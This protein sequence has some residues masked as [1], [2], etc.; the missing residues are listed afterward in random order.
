MERENF[1]TLGCLDR[2]L[3]LRVN[4]SPIL[5]ESN[6]QIE[7]TSYKHW[8]RS[9]RLSLIFIKSHIGKSIRDSIPDYAKMNEYLKVIEKQFETSDKALASTV[10]AK[11]CSMKF[12]DTKRVREH[13]MKMRDIAAQLRLLD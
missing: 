3:A 13:I 8:E 2:D 6:T 1:P 9:Y 5:T 12:N 4:E 7:K 10:M 11:M